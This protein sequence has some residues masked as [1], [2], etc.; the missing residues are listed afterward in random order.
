V[1][2]R[3]PGRRWPNSI[4]GCV[5]C[6]K[7][8]DEISYGRRGLCISCAQSEISAGTIDNW[9]ILSRKEKGPRN[10][11]AVYRTVTH[12]GV[13][14]LSRRVGVE[15]SDVRGWLEGYPVPP[16]YNEFIRSL[17]R[18]IR[19]ITSLAN[20]GERQEEFFKYRGLGTLIIDGKIF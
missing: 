8:R 13:K 18:E 6:A 15:P 14:E 7:S 10:T 3:S 2:G 11:S 12:I 5:K 1:I 19:R 17:L 4:T 16:H 9:D 20:R